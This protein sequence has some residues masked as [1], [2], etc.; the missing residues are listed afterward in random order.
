MT[1]ASAAMMKSNT[2]KRSTSSS[3]RDNGQDSLLASKRKAR[4]LRFS[5]GVIRRRSNEKSDVE[6]KQA[7][8]PECNM[9]QLCYVIP[10]TMA[11]MS[12]KDEASEAVR[13]RDRNR[14][15]D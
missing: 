13:M 14:L 6:A 8:V 1:N 15:K 10:S 7:F 4:G 2:R 5:F 3:E 12:M 9:T 11:L